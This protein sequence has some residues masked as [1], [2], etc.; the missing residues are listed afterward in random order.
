[1]RRQLG[2]PSPSSGPNARD[3]TANAASSY[4]VV[5]V[6]VVVLQQVEEA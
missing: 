2:P 3:A 6:V 4:L 5:V 1:M